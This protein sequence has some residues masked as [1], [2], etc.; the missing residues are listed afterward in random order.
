LLKTNY[1]KSDIKIMAKRTG[2]K[3]GGKST[4]GKKGGK[5]K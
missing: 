1:Y 3:S 2:T 5:R 4:G